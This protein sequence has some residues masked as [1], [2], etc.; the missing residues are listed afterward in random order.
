MGKKEKNESY[1]SSISSFG[2][3]NVES[4]VTV[5]ERGQMV[6]P[7]EIREKASIKAGDKLTVISLRKKDKICCLSLIKADEFAEMVK[8]LLG[9]MFKEMTNKEGKK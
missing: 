2:C 3:C 6:L 1:C 4:V 9:P 7:K 8:D 5:D